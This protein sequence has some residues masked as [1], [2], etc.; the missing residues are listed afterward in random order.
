MTVVINKVRVRC[1][2]SEEKKC[3][4]PVYGRFTWPG[5]DEKFACSFHSLLLVVYADAMG[6][7][8]QIIPL[9]PEEIEG[10]HC[11]QHVREE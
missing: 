1:E 8:L 10:K 2:M 9:K 11:N 3:D 4:L 6:F 7:N 5:K